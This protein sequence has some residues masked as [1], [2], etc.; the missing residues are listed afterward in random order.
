MFRHSASN[1]PLWSGCRKKQNERNRLPTSLIIV[2]HSMFWPGVASLPRRLSERREYVRTTHSD[3]RMHLNVLVGVGFQ[4]WAWGGF[5][6]DVRSVFRKYQ[7]IR[8]HVTNRLRASVLVSRQGYSNVVYCYSST[9][10][11]WLLQ[12][13]PACLDNNCSS[14]CLLS[15]C[16]RSSTLFEFLVYMNVSTELKKFIWE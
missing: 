3:G 5:K 8:G 13:L 12:S 2:P 7:W 10:C 9:V 14:R 6:P 1:F 4:T 15:R 16:T 11:S